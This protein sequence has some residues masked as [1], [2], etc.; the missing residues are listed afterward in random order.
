MDRRDAP[1]IGV[2][3]VDRTELPD[4]FARTWFSTSER[5]LLQDY[6]WPIAAGW[7]AKEAAFKACNEGES[8]R[9]GCLQIVDVDADG[10]RVHYEAQR[11]A[12]VHVDVID[13]AIIAIARARRQAQRTSPVADRLVELIRSQVGL[14]AS[15]QAY[16]H[17]SFQLLTGARRLAPN[18]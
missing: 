9:P 17:S 11:M 6:R 18:G 4:S 2:D 15:A 8:F 14:A 13:D 3:A 7:A 16:G 12:D 5:R 1:G 10:C